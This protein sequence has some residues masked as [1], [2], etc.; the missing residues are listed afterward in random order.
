VRRVEELLEK[1]LK[2]L[3]ST[4]EHKNVKKFQLLVD[5]FVIKHGD[6]DQRKRVA[7]SVQTAMFES[8]GTCVVEIIDGKALEFNNRF[9]LDGMEFIEPVPHLFNY[10]NPFGACPKCEGFGRIMGIDEAKVIPD[11]VKSIYEGAVAC[12]TGEKTGRWLDRFIANAEAYDFPIHRPYHDLTAKQKRLLWKGNSDIEGVD[13]FFSAL[14]AKSYKIQNRVMLARYRGR[15]VCSECEGG[16]LRKEAVCVKVSGLSLPE[17][18]SMS[19]EELNDFFADIDLTLHE[20]QIAERILLEVR[21]RLDTMLRVGLNYLNLDRIS[22]TLSGG[23]T[24]RI[25]LTRLLGSNLTS[26]LYLL[27]EPSVGLHP[28][29]THQLIEVL[30]HLRDLGNTVVVVEH[31]EEVI[32]K[33]DEII[34]IGPRAGIHGGHL[35]YAGSFDNMLIEAKNSLTSEYLTGVRSLVVPKRRKIVDKIEIVNARAHNLQGVNA[36]IPLHAMTCVTGVSGSGKTSLVRHVLYPAIRAHIGEIFSGAAAQGTLTGDLN[37]IGQVEFI[38]QNPIGRSS[39]S[40]PI[41]YVKAYDPIRKL[42]TSQQISKVRGYKPK[43]FSFNVEGGR[44][45]TCKGDGEIVVEMQFLADVKLQ[46]EECRGL[47]FKREILEVE[48]QGKNIHDVLDLS[49]EEALEFFDSEKEIIKKIKPLDDV[50]LGYIKLG[51]TSSTLSGGEAQ[52]VKLA[53]FL[54]KESDINRILF[55]FD[56]P[57]TGL[58][59]HDILKLLTSLNALV[60]LGHTV[61]IIEH[62]MDVIKSADWVIDLGPEG[63]TGGGNLV[64]QGTPEEVA[65]CQDSHT[66]HFLKAKLA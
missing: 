40:N 60:E 14:L 23:E 13:D 34:D 3:E 15:T 37:M 61:L 45:E 19:I 9:E 65:Q 31:E 5:R 54:G 33:A 10:N 24:Q 56:E 36:T 47:R 7:D 6:E 48:Y 11:Q 18:T 2:V 59:F 28:K 46:C 52:R 44:C 63:G 39:R 32:R 8:D 12:W 42:F 49:V 66:G 35:V 53:S 43:H 26:S 17:L 22:S 4:L 50:G 20:E 64:C 57:T 30:Y 62:N 38:N 51:Q 27:D 16:R 55:I 41:T 21:T 29:D 58:H 25:N 1:K